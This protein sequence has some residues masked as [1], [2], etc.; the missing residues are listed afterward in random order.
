M[1]TLYPPECRLLDYGHKDL[2]L[3][4]NAPE[5][6]WKPILDWIQARAD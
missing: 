2:W 6:V 3:A 5:L 1:V 4:A